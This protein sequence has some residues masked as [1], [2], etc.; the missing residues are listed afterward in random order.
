MYQYM[1]WFGMQFLTFPKGISLIT[2]QF[3]PAHLFNWKHVAVQ[4]ADKLANHVILPSECSF[5]LHDYQPRAKLS[6]SNNKLT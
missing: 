4:R 1:L 5:T 6:Y 3:Q 2:S